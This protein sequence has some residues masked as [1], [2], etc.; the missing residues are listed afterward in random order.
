MAGS[1]VVAG[2]TGQITLQNAAVAT[3][4]GTA[5]QLLGGAYSHVLVNVTIATTATITFEAALNESTTYASVLGRNMASGAAATTATATGIYLVD[6][7]GMGSFRARIS[8]WTAGAVSAVGVA[9][10]T[11]SVDVTGNL[12]GSSGSASSFPGVVPAVWD[13][14]AGQWQPIYAPRSLGD[15]GAAGNSVSAGLLLYNGTTYDRAR[16]T[17][18]VMD[19]A[20]ELPAAAALADA[21]ANPTTP[22]VGAAM[23]IFNG[24]TWDRWRSVTSSGSASNLFAGTVGLVWDAT[25]AQWNP[26]YAPRGVADGVALGNSVSVGPWLYNGGTWDRTRNTAGGALLASAARTATTNSPDQTNYNATGVVVIVDVSANGGVFSLTPS[27]QVKDDTSGNYITILTGTAISSNT[28]QRLRVGASLT[29]VANAAAN[30]ILSR[31]WRVV[32]TPGD[33]TSVTYSVS[34]SYIVG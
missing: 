16:G 17:S 5:M 31:T 30:D 9:V 20:T 32:C 28:N 29:A 19:V 15:A 11:P 3:G 12:L 2:R 33:A 25:G 21:T 10:Y 34:H 24:T 6:V 7:R 18:G 26:V 13:S 22:I 14:V 23:E 27:I 4:N 1:N 8:A